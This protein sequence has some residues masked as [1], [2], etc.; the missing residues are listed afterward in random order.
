MKLK[1][2]A[3]LVEGKIVCGGERAEENVDFAFASDLMSDVLTL[4]DRDFILLTG[5]ANV[6]LV[7]T[8]EMSDVNY[9]MLCRRK[10]A[11]EEMLELARENGM[12]IIETPVSLF[13][14]S[15]LLYSAGVKALF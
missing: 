4:R 1:D 5:L 3:A 13:K 15:G 7:R 14:A 11:N 6:Q 9:M 10:R 2:L 12:L 8:A